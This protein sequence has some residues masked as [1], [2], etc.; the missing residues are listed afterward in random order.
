MKP[1]AI[2]IMVLGLSACNVMPTEYSKSGVYAGASVIGAVS[3]FDSIDSRDDLDQVDYTAG[4]GVRAGYRFL[5]RFALEAAYTGAMEWNDSDVKMETLGAQGKVYPLTGA[6]QPYGL[7]GAGYA[8]GKV[9]DEDIDSS[10]MYWRLGIGLE[11]YIIPVLPF[12]LE[13]DYTMPTDDI[14]ELQ[15]ASVHLGALFRF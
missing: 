8:R 4:V 10:S 13:V 2:L 1:L 12:F 5:D 9:P 11:T 3:N 14:K 7:I 6:V 15:Y